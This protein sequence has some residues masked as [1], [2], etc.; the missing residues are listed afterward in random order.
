MIPPFAPVSAPMAK[1]EPVLDVVPKTVTVLSHAGPFVPVAP[2]LKYM[3]PVA[4]GVIE[5]PPLVVSAKA[6][7]EICDVAP[8]F[9]VLVPRIV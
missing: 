9:N 8:N 1:A 3:E 2:V 6:P 5:N 4:D 7:T